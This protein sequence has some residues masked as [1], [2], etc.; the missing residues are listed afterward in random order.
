[1][2]VVDVSAKGR[3]NGSKQLR[4]YMY[5]F[6]AVLLNMDKMI[7][8]VQVS[9]NYWRVEVNLQGSLYKVMLVVV[10]RRRSPVVV[11]PNV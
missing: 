5:P 8:G 2:S 11:Y 6:T 7:Q 9:R 10:C 1:M 3:S 4:Q